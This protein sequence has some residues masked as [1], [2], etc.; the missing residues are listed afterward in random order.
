MIGVPLQHALAMATLNPGRFV[1]GRGQL[2]LGSR[3]DLVRFRWTGEI[4]IQD[5]WF[6]GQRV[7]A[8]HN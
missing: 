7:S 6:A 8:H 4:S 5:V 1:G 3:A 2:A